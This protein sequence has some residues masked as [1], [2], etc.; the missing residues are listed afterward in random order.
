ME[1]TDSDLK[2][3]NETRFRET[4]MEFRGLL[5]WGEDRAFRQTVNSVNQLISDV[6]DNIDGNR[7]AE[8]AEK[9]KLLKNN[10]RHIILSFPNAKQ[11]SLNETNQFID[12]LNAS[13]LA[14]LEL[15]SDESGIRISIDQLLHD[16]EKARIAVANEDFQLGKDIV[17]SIAQTYIFCRQRILQASVKKTLEQPLLEQ[18][19]S[20]IQSMERSGGRCKKLDLHELEVLLDRGAVSGIDSIRILVLGSQEKLASLFSTL[21]RQPL[22][23]LILDDESNVLL[24]RISVS[25]NFNIYIVGATTDS[26][27]STCRS[28]ITQSSALINLFTKKDVSIDKIRELI[29]MSYEQKST[30]YIFSESEGLEK[31]LGINFEAINSNSGAHK[32]VG[33]QSEK[34]CRWLATELYRL[35]IS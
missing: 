11:I 8:A 30:D 34:F 14:D 3:S 15:G 4:V 20:K 32:V 5:R 35:P 12:T 28:L 19:I 13:I 26:E 18:A 29:V 31:V 2:L 10:M 33:L 21:S 27:V 7:Q 17:Q 23:K 22:E 16:L 1:V 9:L 25:R 6:R 24:L